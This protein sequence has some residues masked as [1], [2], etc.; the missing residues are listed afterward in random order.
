MLKNRH[1]RYG[2][3]HV[4]IHWVM[5]IAV[6][7]MFILG[8]WMVELDYY[9][10]WYKKGPDLHRSIGVFILLV[11]VLRLIWKLTNPRPTPLPSH[12][13]VEQVGAGFAHWTMYGLITLMAVTGYL[14]STADGRSVSVFGWFE[15]PA[16]IT[17]ID[18]Q[19]DIA[20]EI[21]FWLAVTLM[22][23][24]VVHALAALK[25]HFIDRDAT[26]RRMFGKP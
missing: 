7:G 9:D 23:V 18:N 17:S 14:I 15:I 1:D 4:V 13:R 19:E 24:A 5:G 3:V 22:T 6:V 8:L 25:H 16:T 26:L 2:L 20:G 11:L 21:H 10:P 12:T